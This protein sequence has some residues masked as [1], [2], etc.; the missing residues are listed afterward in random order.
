MQRARSAA[1][2]TAAALLLAVAPGVHAECEIPRNATRAV[3][4]AYVREPVNEWCVQFESCIFS[5]VQ[6]ARLCVSAPMSLVLAVLAL[7]V[8]ATAGF[9]SS[10]ASTAG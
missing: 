9:R 1:L 4:C 5:A 6:Q 3:V 2:L 7:A 8:W 10:S